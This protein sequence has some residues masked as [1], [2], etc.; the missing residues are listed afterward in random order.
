MNKFESVTQPKMWFVALLLSAAVAGCSGGGGDPSVGGTAELV[1]MVTTVTPV[2]HAVDV[3]V[4]IKA[5]TAAF[6]KTMNPLTL[7]PASFTLTCPAGTSITGAVTYLA[8]SRLAKLTLPTATH[9]PPNTLCTATVTT[10]ARDTTGMPLASNFSWAFTTGTTLDDIA[11]FVTEINIANGATNVPINTKVSAT[12]GEW[13]DPLTI[14][15]T[16]FTLMQGT[17]PVP[18][19]VIYIG[20][21]AVF[22]PASPLAANTTYTATITTGAKSAEDNALASDFVWSWTTAA[23]ADTTAPTVAGT[24]HTNLAK[25]VPINTK[26]AV[27]FSEGMYPLTINH[28]N[29][30]LK[31]TASGA[32]VTGTVSYS[33]V[34][35]TYIPL[36]NLAP[37]TSYTVTVKGGGGGVQDLAGN[38]M[39]S[40]FT[41]SWTTA[42]TADT[43]APTVSSF[44]HTSDTTNVPIN[45]KVGI[46]FSE[47]MDSLTITNANLILKETASGKDVA[48]IVSHS[49]TGSAFIPLSTLTS[50]T[51]YTFTVKGGITGVKDLASNT[52]TSNFNI[53]W[54]TAISA[55]N[56]APR[57]IKTTQANG[58]SNVAINTK[59]GATF[60]EWLDPLTINQANL[61]MHETASGDAVAGLISYSG[62]NVAFVPLR[63][64]APNTSYTI[65]I[66]GGVKGVTDLAGNPMPSDYVWSWFT[67]TDSNLIAPTVILASPIDYELG[68][69]INKSVSAKFSDEMDPLTISSA[70]FTVAGVTGTVSYDATNKIAIFKPE[71]VFATGTT[72]TATI[73]TGVT[74]LAG[75]ALTVNKVWRFTTA[76]FPLLSPVIN[77]RS[78]SSFGALGGNA[79]V[80]S[81][82]LHTLINGDIGATAAAT[83]VTGFHDR[84]LGC[85]YTETP[86]NIGTVNGMIYTAMPPPT[87]S[88]LTEGTETTFMIAAQAN[89]DA[90]VAYNAL[91]AMP[92]GANLTAM[93]VDAIPLINLAGINPL[94]GTYTAPTGAFV[95]QGG[96]MILDAYGDTDAVW[97]FQMATTLTVGGPGTA[98]PQ[99]IILAGGAQAKNVFWQVGSTATINAAGGGTMVG[100]IIAREGVAFS[101]EGNN[102]IVMLEGRVLSINGPVTLVNTVINVPAP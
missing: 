55:D 52:M 59:V 6:T 51:G 18:G 65:T 41:I 73:T 67:N 98:A 53:S 95:I 21:S 94:P 58:V 96:D 93:P 22:T 47:G 77:L 5:I 43:T 29:F 45:T 54:T 90:L 44:Y 24:I 16:T 76:T 56:T 26:V 11:P 91:V 100:N 74:D 57:V 42:A 8:E 61:S 102:A 46:I 15:A 25:N 28:M 38:P 92:A 64:L 2:P 34:N 3:P 30:T 27:S 69:P 62:V 84:G 40:N 19:T 83:A 66:K 63:S 1:P 87:V 71:S 14:T 101:S 20:V 7:T 81:S 60:S 78:A 32:A 75:N 68:V 97:V 48:G 23:V 31:E 88:C 35:A 12:F 37:N 36:Y 50:N 99:N 13:M 33:G 49:G 39:R 86:L 4:N 10:E 17:T 89:A 85:N 79:A 80:T 9:L 72:Y 70:N 82:G